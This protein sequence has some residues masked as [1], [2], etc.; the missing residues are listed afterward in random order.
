MLIN[1]LK[2]G[3]HIDALHHVII[4]RNVVNVPNSKIKKWSNEYLLFRD[5]DMKELKYYS[6]N[7]NVDNYITCNFALTYD[8]WGI[9]CIKLSCIGQQECDYWITTVNG[10]GL[11]HREN[12]IPKYPNSKSQIFSLAYNTSPNLFSATFIL[13]KGDIV[14]IGNSISEFCPYTNPFLT[15]RKILSSLQDPLL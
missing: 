10:E 14:K 3:S 8:R 15:K 12:L 7:N 13:Q 4:V 11:M 5:F 9:K 2:I 6:E 1:V